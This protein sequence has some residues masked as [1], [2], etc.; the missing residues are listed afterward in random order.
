MLPLRRLWHVSLQRLLRGQWQILLRAGCLATSA[1]RTYD[2]RRAWESD[3]SLSGRTAAWHGTIACSSW[4]H[5]WPSWP[6]RHGYATRH[7]PGP[8]HGRSTTRRRAASRPE[9]PARRQPWSDANHEQAHDETRHDGRR[10]SVHSCQRPR[11]SCHTPSINY[12]P[13]SCE[14][15][16]SYDDTC[17]THQRHH[18][19]SYP[20]T[21]MTARRSS[22]TG[23]PAFFVSNLLLLYPGL[24][25]LLM[26]FMY[27][28]SFIDCRIGDFLEGRLECDV[29]AV[30]PGMAVC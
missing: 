22:E 21:S 1:V 27:T 28:H 19:P 23:C 26:L 3:R 8:E 20:L 30:P 5:S 6:W 15:S 17:F 12:K 9:T 29:F 2:E 7:G 4:Q 16:D 11:S 13:P 25:R 24:S 10:L 18:Q 14:D